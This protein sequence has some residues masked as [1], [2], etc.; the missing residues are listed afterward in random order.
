[1]PDESGGRP[2]INAE[3]RTLLKMRLFQGFTVSEKLCSVGD[4]TPFVALIQNVNTPLTAGVPLMVAVP[5]GPPTNDTP[6]GSD[7][8][9]E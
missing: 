2:Y 7:P 9:G 5:L 3:N 8:P 4:P 1:M 6:A